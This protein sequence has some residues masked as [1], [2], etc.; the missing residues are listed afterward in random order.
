MASHGME[1]D[2]KQ[3]NASSHKRPR[4]EDSIE[5]R[6]RPVEGDGTIC[7]TP[8]AMLTFRRR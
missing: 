3:S 2:S 8:T 1:G 6:S 4:E 7:K 5:S